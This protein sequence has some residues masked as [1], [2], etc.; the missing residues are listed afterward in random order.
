MMIEPTN[1]GP[2]DMK[3]C[4]FI[5]KICGCEMVRI[6]FYNLELIIS[7]L[8]KSHCTDEPMEIYGIFFYYIGEI[9]RIL[10]L[11]STIWFSISLYYTSTVFLFL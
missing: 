10:V 6:I 5:S 1:V 8:S 3:G 7:T 9:M 2:T 4:M 11:V